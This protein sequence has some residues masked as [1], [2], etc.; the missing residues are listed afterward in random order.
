MP[1][2]YNANMVVVPMEPAPKRIALPKITANTPLVNLEK[3]AQFLREEKGLQLSVSTI[4]EYCR[5]RRWHEGYH[6]VKPGRSYLINLAAVYESIA[7]GKF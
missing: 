2:T 5:S 1:R 4:R 6:W 3:A 7:H